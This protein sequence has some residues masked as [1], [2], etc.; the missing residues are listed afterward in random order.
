[1]TDDR[2][3]L[4]IHQVLQSVKALE[5]SLKTILKCLDNDM[6]RKHHTLLSRELERVDEI[7]GNIEYLK[8]NFVRSSKVLGSREEVECRLNFVVGEMA[9]KYGVWVPNRHMDFS[10]W[11]DLDLGAVVFNKVGVRMPQLEVVS[12]I[13]AHPN[14]NNGHMEEA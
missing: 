10:C 5:R 6:A 8:D 3:T 2:Q 1:M 4:G 14:F 12:R 7:V 13:K 9:S 11:E